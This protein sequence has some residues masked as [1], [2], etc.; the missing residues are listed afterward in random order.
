M[1]ISYKTNRL[2]KQL[3]NASEIKKAFGVNANRVS[4]RLDD[5]RAAPNLQVLKQLPAANC[6]QL[7]GRKNNEWAVD[8]SK[9]HRMI[10]EIAHDP[11]PMDENN[12]IN[13]LLVTE[14]C[15]KETA[16]YH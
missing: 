13:T 15:I 1:E 12:A 8:I 6:H 9:N 16:D 2:K 5:I 10:F 3:S 14:I 11:I 7:Q 4:A